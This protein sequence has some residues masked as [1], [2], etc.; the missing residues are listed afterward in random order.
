MAAD[1]TPW[2]Y[3]EDSYYSKGNFTVEFR[4]SPLEP[5]SDLDEPARLRALRSLLLALRDET[6]LKVSSF[7]DVWDVATEPPDDKLAAAEDDPDVNTDDKPATDAAMAEF[8]VYNKLG[9]TSLA[10]LRRFMEA[11][12]VGDVPPRVVVVDAETGQRFRCTDFTIRYLF[13]EFV[14][15][16]LP[17]D[18]ERLRGLLATEDRGYGE[19][20]AQSR[21]GSTMLIYRGH[22][23]REVTPQ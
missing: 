8:V 6:G 1:Q 18:W 14:A 16:H 10:K 3:S 13:H 2:R 11:H 9:V 22:R 23:Y 7:V 21:E 15:H 19:L 4:C 12:L 5:D 20:T 17:D